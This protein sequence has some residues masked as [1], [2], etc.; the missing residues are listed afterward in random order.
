MTVPVPPVARRVPLERRHHGDV[1]LD[2]Y[3][4]LREKENP[5]VIAHLEAENAYTEATLAPL[6]PLRERLFEEIRSRTKETD[7]S[8]PV[9]EGSWWYFSRSYEGRQY[10]VHC[11][12]PITGP[13]DWTPPSIAEGGPLVGEQVVLD[14]NAQAEGHDFFSLGSFDVSADGRYL[15]FGTDVEGDER[16]TLRIR[17]LQT[18]EDL[19]DVIEGTG[20]GATFGADA[21]FVFYPTV[22]ASWR[23]DTI[24]RHAVGS[25]APDE[26]VFA[27]PDERYW[28]GVGLT[29]SRRFLVIEIGS[30]ITSECLLLDASDPTGS[31]RSVWPRRE[32][33][34][35]EVEH[36]VVDGRDRLLIVHNDGALDFEIVEEPADLSLD[37]D[38]RARER[39]VVVPH[40]EGRR[41]EGVDA[42]ARHVVVSYRSEGATRLGLLREDGG[43]ARLEEIVF[44]EPLYDAGLAGNPEWEQTSLRLAYTSF[45]TPSTVL[46][47]D[48]ATGE[49]TVLKQQPVLGEYDPALYVQRREWA[50]AEDGMRVPLSLVWRRDA[51]DPD[52]AP[53]PLLLYGYGSYEAS[54]D[55]GFSIARLSLLDRGVVFAIAHVRGGGEMGRSWYENGKTLTKRTTF[56]D[57]VSAARHL[58]DAG[59][60]TPERLV[61][62]G[63]SAGGLLMGAVA[64]LAPEAFAGILAQVPFVDALTSIL[65]PSLPLTVIEWDEWG[66]PLHDAEV[67]AYMKSYS[68]YENVREGVQYPRILAT[69]SLNDTRVLYVEPAKWVARLREVGAPAL[70]RTEM[71]AGHGGVSGRY[72]RWREIAFEYA[73]TLDVLGLA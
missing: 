53:A 16:Y 10:A 27:E 15:L 28:I 57:F 49:R 37:A 70:L 41:I 4:W 66:D 73:W 2:P 72:E 23:P 11:R 48:V 59:F 30:K 13:D 14:G 21:R 67:Y 18:G 62:Q 6:A 58:V 64:N 19:P 32:G 55:P 1:V 39:R 43:D 3:E 17:D 47:L 61:A 44:D 22:D 12:A 29:R 34:E 31:F 8:V 40:Q 69:T 51:A 65:D 36:A 52:S 25:G 63:G 20:G 7:L 60:T 71:T 46:A 35:Y 45:I 54:I 26:V 9:R 5:E 38:A 33:V 42:F 56:T 24:W 68:P 50:V